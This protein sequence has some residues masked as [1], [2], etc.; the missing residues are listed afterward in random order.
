MKR[1]SY[2]SDSKTLKTDLG[3]SYRLARPAVLSSQKDYYIRKNGTKLH[4]VW[5]RVRK[6]NRL[7]N[8][9]IYSRV[10]LEDLASLGIMKNWIDNDVSTIIRN[11]NQ[12]V[13]SGLEA[14][15]LGLWSSQTPGCIRS[16]YLGLLTVPITSWDPVW[17][18][19]CQLFPPLQGLAVI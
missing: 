15:F 2:K 8:T 14:F 9:I 13:G 5:E 1:Q 6:S 12:W 4:Q 19:E 18:W 7:E 3:L 11:R 17:F 10:K 16:T